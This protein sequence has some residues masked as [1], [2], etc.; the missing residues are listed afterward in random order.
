MVLRDGR[1]SDRR[2]GYKR[3]AVSFGALF[4]L[5]RSEALFRNQRAVQ[6][7]EDGSHAPDN[8]VPGDLAS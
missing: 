6:E 7:P 4:S 3:G 5:L 1:G 2:M 8:V